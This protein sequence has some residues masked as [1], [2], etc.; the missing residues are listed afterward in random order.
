MSKGRLMKV[1]ALGGLF[2]FIGG[3]LFAPQKGEKTREKLKDALDKGKTKFEE[4][5][6]EYGKKEK[7]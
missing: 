4:L 2:G 3:L 7:E 6:E 5:K 1:L